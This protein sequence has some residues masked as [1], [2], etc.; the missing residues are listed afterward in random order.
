MLCNSFFLNLSNLTFIVPLDWKTTSTA[1]H[2]NQEEN[3]SQ[4]TMKIVFIIQIVLKAALQMRD[5]AGD[6]L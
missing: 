2:K 5:Y 1:Y 3:R 6:S 4:T